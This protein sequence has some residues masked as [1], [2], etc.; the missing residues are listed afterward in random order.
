M[1]LLFS[2]CPL[3]FQSRTWFLNHTARG[4]NHS[5][6]GAFCDFGLIRAGRGIG[7]IYLFDNIFLPQ[8]FK[9][10]RTFSFR[11]WVRCIVLRLQFCLRLNQLHVKKKVR[12]VLFIT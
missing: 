7:V 4:E 1:A 5:C 6:R 8:S 3:A 2:V 10:K 9:N 12:M 11:C